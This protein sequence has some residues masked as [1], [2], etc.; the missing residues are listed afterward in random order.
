MLGTH[1][2]R[3]DRTKVTCS[4]TMYCVSASFV[5][6]VS[7]LCMSACSDAH[8]GLGGANGVTAKEGETIK[9]ML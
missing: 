2:Y 3:K 5:Q 9:A 7:H 1:I 4:M 6:L 8:L